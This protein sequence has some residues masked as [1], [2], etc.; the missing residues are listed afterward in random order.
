[1]GTTS[2]E[3]GT[4]CMQCHQRRGPGP[5]QFTVAGTAYGEDGAP[6]P[7]ATLRLA[8]A[9]GEVVL[10]VESDAYGNFFSTAPLPWP[11][12]E[13]FPSVQSADAKAASAM[14]FSTL[15]GACNLCHT[16][17]MRVVLRDLP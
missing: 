4:N 8:D 11:E 15:S 17:V 12:A 1:G 5:G 7:D 3:A 6:R 10:E 14:P 9:T 13:L 16:P 2:H